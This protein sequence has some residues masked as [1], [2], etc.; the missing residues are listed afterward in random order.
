MLQKTIY[1]LLILFFTVS[2]AGYLWEILIYFLMNGSFT[3]RG[4]FH[5]PWLPVYGL[6]AVLLAWLLD[7]LP[8]RIKRY[9]HALFLLSSCVCTATEYLL[10]LY[11]E[12]FR[13]VRYWDY[14]GW[15][16]SVKGRVC[17]VSFLFFGFGG[18]LLDGWLMP[19]IR[20]IVTRVTH[21]ASAPSDGKPSASSGHA[22]SA[23]VPRAAACSPL[24]TCRVR[25]PRLLQFLFWT[26]CIL[27]TA[28]FIYSCAHP[29]VGPNI[30]S[31]IR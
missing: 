17:L 19:A 16:L 1:P 3:N 13:H 20:R 25:N 28:D 31:R 26:V 2:V 10:A 23:S 4:F 27:F 15:P 11:L 24:S 7:A 9:P 14:T 18:P 29:N 21:F 5:G 8:A 22:A 30:A 12:T 6:G